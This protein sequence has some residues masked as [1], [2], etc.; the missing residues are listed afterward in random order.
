MLKPSLELKEK[1]N[2]KIKQYI[3]RRFKKITISKPKKICGFQ[4][5]HL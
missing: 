4:K 5:K 2:N 3:V 1:R